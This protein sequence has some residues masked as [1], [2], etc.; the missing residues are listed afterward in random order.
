MTYKHA[1]T[2]QEA[3]DL[4]D[5]HEGKPHASIQWKGTDVC[6]DVRCLCGYH[7]HVDATFAY[8]FRCKHCGRTFLVGRYV[9]LIEVDECE[10]NCVVEDYDDVDPA[11]LGKPLPGGEILT[12]HQQE[13]QHKQLTEGLQDA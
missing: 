5:T 3:Y 11:G 6:M 8:Y 9:E 2:E 4:Q 1:K 7:S 10:S 12:V 13:V